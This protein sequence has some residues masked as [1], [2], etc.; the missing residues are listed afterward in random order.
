MRTPWRRWLVVL[1]AA[2]TLTSGITAPFVVRAAAAAPNQS[3]SGTA[4]SM[5]QTNGTVDSLAV[6]NGVLYAGGT[7]SAVRPPGA[8]NG[9][10]QTTRTD[11]AA[12]STATGT[13]TSFDPTLNGTVY[14]VAISPDGS[15]LYVGGSFTTV[16]GQTRNRF[17]AFDLAT[18]A[19]DPT[20]VPSANGIG[21]SIAVYGSTVYLGGTFGKINN[22]AHKD[23]A[24][25]DATT[26]V[27]LSGFTATADGEVASMA[28]PADGSRLLVAGD[29]NTLA[30]QSEHAIGSLD[31]T[32]GAPETWLSNT[33]LPNTPTCNSD[34]TDVYINGTVAYVAGEGAQPGCYDGDFAANVSDGSLV[35]N[36]PCEG[37][38]QALMMVD[39]VLYKGSH[40]HDCSYNEGGAGGGFTG[41][42]ARSFFVVYRLIAQNPADGTFEHWSPNTNGSNG[43]NLGPLAMA[44]DGTQLFVGGDFTSVN[45]KAQEGLARFAP[46]TS[47]PPTKPAVAPLVYPSGP[48]Q[49]AIS[50]PAV[51][52]SDNGVLTYTLY[53]GST[54]VGTATAESWPW[55]QPTVRFLDSG[56]KSGTSYTYTYKA[57]DGTTTTAASPKST[58]VTALATVPTYQS[59]VSSLA[60]SLN[61]HLDDT[62]TQAT[63]SS[64]NGEVGDFEGGVTTGVPGALSGDA[65]I[66]LDGITGYVV[67][68]QPQPA[69]TDFTESAWFNSTTLT[70][71]AILGTSSTPTGNGGT[72][73]D[74]VWM[75]NDGQIVFAMDTPPVTFGGFPGFTNTTIRSPHTYNDGHW[76]QVVATYDGSTMSLYVDGALVA[77]SAATATNPFE[78][79]LLGGYNNI[80]SFAHVF[81]F[82][83][84]PGGPTSPNS[85]HFQGSLDEVSTYPTALTAAQVASLWGSG[86]EAP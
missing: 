13:P 55:A 32:T 37:A 9:T 36:S 60:P 62:G 22:I 54:V 40:M 15:K 57:S 34:G 61:W 41:A 73:D 14:S 67:S 79:Y 78:G 27:L 6:S 21:H 72:N 10:S 18:G 23:L 33:I 65:A 50:V 69:S 26:G 3:L 64:G 86:A 38:T 25:V 47:A 35:W 81:G 63:D 44:T 51:T 71:G 1:A 70:G 49:L 4:S 77:S 76:H 56:L 46:G 75:D 28:L 58:A 59:E 17:A 31:P 11:L 68:D 82:G 16:N 2:V 80:G 66:G 12:F 84:S 24:A 29:F 53:R 7:F 48:D 39:G 5:Y 19:L 43:T 42:L 74:T 52:D 85:Y 83:A 30:G 8:A 20:W 45:N